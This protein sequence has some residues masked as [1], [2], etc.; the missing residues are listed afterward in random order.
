MKIKK[1]DYY[2]FCLESLTNKALKFMSL[3]NIK[4]SELEMKSQKWQGRLVETSSIK[5][6]LYNK[7][8]ENQN[9]RIT[10]PFVI[11]HEL[12]H[13]FDK[14]LG[15]RKDTG[16]INEVQ[17]EQ[18]ADRFIYKF[19]LEHLCVFEQ[20]VLQTFIENFSKEKVSFTEQQKELIKDE[21]KVYF[22]RKKNENKRT[23]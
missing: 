13:Y 21:Y 19:C 16:V 2:D 15:D 10:K 20:F 17:L 5:E 7:S 18:N 6:I 9:G 23:G 12:G 1:E 14:E 8:S 3:N 11:L 4:F 22:K